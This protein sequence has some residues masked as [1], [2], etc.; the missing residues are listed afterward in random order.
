MQI[1]LYDIHMEKFS[2]TADGEYCKR[3]YLLNNFKVFNIKDKRNEKFEF[4]YHEFN[5]IIFFKSGNVKYN[6]EGKEYLLSP[7]DILLV[8]RGD[9][10][11]PVISE[12]EIYDRI[13]IWIDDDYL[14]S[15]NLSKCF[16]IAEKQRFN[17]IK[18][19]DLQLF[20]LAEKLTENNEN[21]FASEQYGEA[22][23]TQLLVLIARNEI[24]NDIDIKKYKSNKQIDDVINYLNSNLEKKLSIDIIAEKF[25]ISR[26]HLMHKFKEC[27]GKTIYS[28][29]QSKRL[30]KAINYMNNGMSAK[31]ACFKSGFNDYSVFLKAFKN[32][33]A[34]TPIKYKENKDRE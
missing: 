14:K 28:Y 5:K 32:E 9:I 4:H 22:I 11:R 21:D 34:T 12:N 15:V 26:Y 10:H 29:I 18:S 25:F 27:T 1:V 33:F 23:L 19:A 13:V 8:R 2:Y 24:H 7:Y 30:L 31:Q 17:I 16:E 20:Q 6:I 3:G